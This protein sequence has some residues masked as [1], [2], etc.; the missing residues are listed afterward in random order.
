MKKKILY[1]CSLLISLIL[2]I[3]SLFFN[4]TYSEFSSDNVKDNI[5]N[6]SS[7]DYAGRLPGS[8]ENLLV[9]ELIKKSF[10]SSELVPLNESYMENFTTLCPVD[11]NTIPYLTI[12]YNNIV[13]EELKYGIDFKED[14]INFRNNTLTF[15]KNNTVNINTNSIEVAN[16]TGNYLFYVAKNND[17]S[18]RSSFMSD[19]PYNM[20]IMITTDTYNKILDSVRA[21][22]DVSVHVPFTTE[23]K[24][25]S[26]VVGVLEGSKDNLPPLVITSHYDHLGKDGL[27]N[28][29]TGALDNA[30]GTSFMLELQ[31]SLSTY[32]K[33][34]RDIIF[35]ALNAEEF[36]LLGSKNFAEKNKDK[37][38]GA[39]VINF[40]MIG[41]E[42]YPIT[43]MLGES[44]KDKESELLNS[45][46]KLS[47]K[48]NTPYEVEYRNASD[49]ASFTN[50]GLDSLSF[51]HSDMTKIHT[52]NDKVEFI[53]TDAIDS[54]YT[55]AFEKIQDSC[56]GNLTVFFNNKY[57]I[58][59]LA[60]IFGLLVAAPF[61]HRKKCS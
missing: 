49:H 2:L 1:Y 3:T 33:P 56:Y 38:T 51:C 31:R 14:M 32:G 18:F 5:A 27:G 60:F 43:F 52:P 26:N 21:G 30:S 4:F 29:Y 12:S 61:A 44:A 6:F 34:K 19:Y 25:I 55:I 15:S 39:E 48:H 46:E 36:G 53:S 10:E 20:A 13:I 22:L 45:V 24:T 8:N 23:E 58:L 16:D 59:I 11:S 37:L 42:C 40:D 35:V 47:K 50:I 28:T 17:F 7:Y 57:S 54:V 9:G 41:S